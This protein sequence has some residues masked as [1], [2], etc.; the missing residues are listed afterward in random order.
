MPLWV[1][2]SD[3]SNT[4]F[5]TFDNRKVVAAGLAFRPVQETVRTTLEWDATRSANYVWRAGL[6]RKR[7]AELLKAYRA[8]APCKS[9]L[10]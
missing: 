2:E 6:T 8:L 10:S 5:F 9:S 3:P 7:E 1:P 4:G